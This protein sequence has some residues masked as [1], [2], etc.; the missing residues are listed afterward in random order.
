MMIT[1][2]RL[3]MF[4]RIYNLFSET[5]NQRGKHFSKMYR[6]QKFVSV[7]STSIINNDDDDNNHILSRYGSPPRTVITICVYIHLIYVYISYTIA[8]AAAAAGVATVLPVRV[9]C[10]MYARPFS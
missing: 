4:K 9:A 6:N 8:A 5:G 7:L 3:R 10:I 2:L 1:T